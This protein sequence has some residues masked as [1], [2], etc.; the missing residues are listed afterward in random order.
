MKVLVVEDNSARLA[1][2]KVD[3]AG[4]DVY[5]AETSIR[6]QRFLKKHIFDIIFLDHDLGGR[7]MVESNDQ[8]T[9][10]QVAKAISGSANEDAYIVIHSANVVGANNIKAVLPKAIVCP[11][12]FLNISACVE[13]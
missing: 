4:H 3:L 5:F 8:N 10:Y 1:K 6:A 7:I 9:G 12:C 11:F 13:K 2:F